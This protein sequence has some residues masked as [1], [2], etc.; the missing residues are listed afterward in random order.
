M[1]ILDTL[2]T[3]QSDGM[4]HSNLDLKESATLEEN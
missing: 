2:G 1:R 4:Y 3:S